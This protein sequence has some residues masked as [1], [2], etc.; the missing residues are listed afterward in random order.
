MDP[1]ELS[2]MRRGYPEHGLD[3]TEVATDPFVQFATWFADAVDL[4][5]V[6]PN[7]MV[8][9]TADAAGRPSVRTVLLK[10]YDERGFAFFTNYGSQKAREL[11]ANPYAALVFPWQAMRRQI[12]VVGTASRLPAEESAAYFRIRP[13]DSQ[14]GA[15]ASRQSEVI[16]SRAALDE[17]YAE[18]AARWPPGEVPVPDFWGG[19]IVAPE[20]VEFWQ[21]RSS[22]LHDRLRYRRGGAG[23]IVERLAP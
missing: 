4:G 11:A 15:W 19:F 20:L 5:L 23:W 16:S 8:L 7:A 13:Y 17:R 9:A 3:E 10:A 18:L 6:E 21:G 14:L 1:V 2:R 22:R 12:V